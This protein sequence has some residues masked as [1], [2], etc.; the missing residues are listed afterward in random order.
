MKAVTKFNY[1]EMEIVLAYF[2][3]DE[4]AQNVGTLKRA[5][6]WYLRTK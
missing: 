1:R 5:W 2:R 6:E 3:N 4:I